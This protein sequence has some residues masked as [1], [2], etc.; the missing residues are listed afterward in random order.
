MLLYPDP[1]PDQDPGTGCFFFYKTDD[2]SENESG[3]Y[4][5]LVDMFTIPFRMSLSVLATGLETQGLIVIRRC[6]GR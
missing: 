4:P 2:C 1:Q 6:E 3:D 5:G